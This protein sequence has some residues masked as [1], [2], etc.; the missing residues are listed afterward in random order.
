M[1][2][3]I[4][5]FEPGGAT[6]K[7]AASPTLFTY[8][9]TDT[10]TAVR[11]AGYFAA[12]QTLMRKGD[13][14]AIH[15][16]QGTGNDA[17]HL[18]VVGTAGVNIALTDLNR[19]STAGTGVVARTLSLVP[20]A[21]LTTDLTLAVPNPVAILR[22]SIF[23]TTAY[24]GNTVTLQLGT[25]VGGVDLMAAA[26]IKAAGNVFA[27]LVGP[28]NANVVG[29]TL[30]ARITQTATATAVGAATLILEYLEA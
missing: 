20:T 11:A 3:A 23:T 25:T 17:F 2:F 24:T 16:A 18:L 7:G 26:S 6:A 22:A 4:A 30:F 9:T 19:G 21:A 27:T 29:G 15:S 13:L 1:A 5:G 10:I 28:A 8:R 12:V 14:V